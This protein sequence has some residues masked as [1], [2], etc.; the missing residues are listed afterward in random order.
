MFAGTEISP[1]PDGN[2]CLPFLHSVFQWLQ[3][4]WLLYG[5]HSPGLS[6]TL[7]QFCTL[8]FIYSCSQMANIPLDE[9]LASILIAS[10]YLL[11][12]LFS[13]IFV[14]KYNIPYF[15]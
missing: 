15:I 8:I 10:Q 1:H 2:P 5:H 3:H 14:T 13:A 9:N 7:V 6:I 11:G 4:G 12:Y